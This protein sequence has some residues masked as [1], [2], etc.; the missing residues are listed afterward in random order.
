[1]RIGSW[2]FDSRLDNLESMPKLPLEQWHRVK[3]DLRWL[4]GRAFIRS[5]GLSDKYFAEV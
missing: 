4:R 3:H 1:V 2:M 5:R